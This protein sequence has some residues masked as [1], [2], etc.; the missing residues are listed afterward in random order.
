MTDISQ[1]DKVGDGNHGSMHVK[2]EPHHGNTKEHRISSGGRDITTPSG[3]VGV[4]AVDVGEISSFL[5]LLNQQLRRTNVFTKE[6]SQEKNVLSVIYVHYRTTGSSNVIWRDIN[7]II[8]ERN[9]ISVIYVTL[10]LPR[11]GSLTQ[12]T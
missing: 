11:S 6:F 4:I 3:F 7:W 12:Q 2:Q 8:Q 10:V 1:P 9:L 5:C